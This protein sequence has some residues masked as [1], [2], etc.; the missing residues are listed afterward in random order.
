MIFSALSFFSPF[1][2]CDD[3]AVFAKI[4]Q[5]S[6]NKADKMCRGFRYNKVT[7][8]AFRGGVVFGV[9]EWREYRRMA[10]LK[11]CRSTCDS[12]PSLHFLW[13]RPGG[14]IGR[15]SGL[16]IRCPKGRT[17]SSPVLGTKIRGQRPPI[18]N[19]EAKRRYD[20]LFWRSSF[21]EACSRY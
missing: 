16:K 20:T 15:R 19:P 18:L 13:P 3:L 2:C 21:P 9:S 1:F 5:R 17:G 11:A 14:G 6:M 4:V 12:D 8:H 10:R 7:L